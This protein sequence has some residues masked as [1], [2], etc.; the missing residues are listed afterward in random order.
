MKQI[1][2]DIRTPSEYASGHL[3]DA[4]LIPTESPPQADWGLTERYL[5][6]VMQGKPLA[7]PV[8]VYCRKGIR[9]REAQKM[10]HR[11]GY[12]N[13]TSLGGVEEGQLGADLR[14]GVVSLVG[15]GR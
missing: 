8:Y 12:T 4:I 14:S 7:L 3:P 10:L 9:A 6:M 1:L 11:L 5:W 13:V 15:G 2:L